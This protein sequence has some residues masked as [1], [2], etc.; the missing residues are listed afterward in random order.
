MKIAK[1]FDWEMG[2]RLPFHKGKCKNL[3]GHSYKLIAEV[4]GEQ[5]ENGMVLDY[6]DLK[7]IIAPIVEKLD[8]AFLVY[9]ED[10]ELADALTKL[11]SKSVVVDFHSTAENICNYF[12]SAIKQNGMPANIKRVKIRVCETSDSYAENEITFL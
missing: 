6:Y 3:H 7:K 1:E 9:K 12:L 8:H 4:E 2:H 5:D 10:K 11:N